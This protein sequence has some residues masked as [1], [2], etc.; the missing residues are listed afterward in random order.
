METAWC[1]AVRGFGV[2]KAYPLR[3]WMKKPRR[4]EKYGK[5]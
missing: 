1:L 3:I 5:I 4:R 2:V